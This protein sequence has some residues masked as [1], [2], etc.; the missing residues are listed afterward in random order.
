MQQ[1]KKKS[2]NMTRCNK[3][4]NNPTGPIEGWGILNI[5]ISVYQN[6]A[7]PPRVYSIIVHEDNR[8]NAADLFCHKEHKPVSIVAK[9]AFPKMH[10]DTGEVGTGT[11]TNFYF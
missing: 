11:S 6:W 10:V 2:K 4:K 5:I 8:Y 9:L 1:E 3:S 7:A